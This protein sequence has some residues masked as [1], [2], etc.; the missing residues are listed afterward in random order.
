MSTLEDNGIA[1]GMADTAVVAGTA[2]ADASRD[3]GMAEDGSGNG[4][5]GRT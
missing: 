5:D 1:G 4:D 2:S 3:G